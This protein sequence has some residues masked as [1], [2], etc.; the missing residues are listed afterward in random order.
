MTISLKVSSGYSFLARLTCQQTTWTLDLV[1]PWGTFWSREGDRGLRLRV[2]VDAHRDQ[3]PGFPPASITAAV[4]CD[5]RWTG[6]DWPG[7]CA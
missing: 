2:S 7:L 5:L 3:S 4:W 1:Y 6:G